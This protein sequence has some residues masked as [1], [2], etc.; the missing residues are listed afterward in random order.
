M[1]LGFGDIVGH[2]DRRQSLT[3]ALDS[4]RVAH[5][6]LLEGPRGVGK[7]TLAEALAAALLCAA[8]EHGQACGR[9]PSCAKLDVASH[10]DL[11]RVRPNDK[12]NIV[13]ESV[14]DMLQAIHL[15]AMEGG[16]KVVVIDDAHR[17]GAPVQNAL[18]KTLEEPPRDT[19]L[20]LVTDRPAALLP[21]IQSRCQRL[22]L[23]PLSV[24]D[25]EEVIR[26]RA[27]GTPED[28]RP[29]LA[30]LSEGA[31]GVALAL[32]FDA[33][34]ER[35]DAVEALDRALAPESA[36]AAGEAVQ[37]A[38]ELAK[39]RTRLA[40]FLEVWG[41]WSRDVA[42][43]ACGQP[44]A[45]VNVDRVPALERLA[46]ARG[47]DVALAR[48]EAILESRR[49]LELPFNLNATMVAEQLMLT[50]AEAVPLRRLP[51]HPDAARNA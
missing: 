26:R 47:T 32:D 16:R 48:A 5:A 18:L 45:V 27:P 30:R 13:I 46:E 7:A 50:L 33:L 19:H 44:E 1:P 25:V 39:D 28:A 34:L 23:R 37:R 24:P 42:A 14:R 12:N 21:T 49:Q 3:R 6:L 31:P 35:R 9:C 8:P 38:G 29:L 17:M 22:R 10:P 40:E 11:H 15:R 4:G 43:V 51:Y 2:R 20:L 41:V 36:G